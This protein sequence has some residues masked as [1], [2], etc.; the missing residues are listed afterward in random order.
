V[1]IGVDK[2]FPLFTAALHSAREGNTFEA[3][4]EVYLISG[5]GGGVMAGV[6]LTTGGATEIFLG[7]AWVTAVF[8]MGADG[9]D[10]E[11]VLDVG[12]EGGREADFFVTTGAEAVILVGGLESCLEPF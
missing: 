6:F 8:L 2:G 12:T 10:G 11:G 3:D 1:G 4:A 7:A 9:V 5:K